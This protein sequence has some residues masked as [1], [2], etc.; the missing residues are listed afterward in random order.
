M[1]CR[2]FSSFPG[3]FLG[4]RP[5][6]CLSRRFL[7]GFPGPTFRIG[8]PPLIRQIGFPLRIET[9]LFLFQRQLDIIAEVVHCDIAGVVEQIPATLELNARIE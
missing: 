6:L 7:S 5:S 1:P 2:A 9:A 3:L 4:R 8:K